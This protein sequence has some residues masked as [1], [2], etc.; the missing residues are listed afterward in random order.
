MWALNILFGLAIMGNFFLIINR[1]PWFF[2]MV[3]SLISAAGVNAFYT[4]Y[5]LYPFYLENALQNQSIR[6][7][8]ILI[9][10]GFFLSFLLEAY[11]F[12]INVHLPKKKTA[13]ISPAADITSTT[14]AD[15]SLTGDSNSSDPTESV[16]SSELTPPPPSD[17][18]ETQKPA[19]TETAIQP[20]TQSG[21]V[22]Q[23]EP[24]AVNPENK[25]V[26]PPD[27]TADSQNN[28]L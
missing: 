12:G 15:S 14:P 9:L 20:P 26:L 24:V 1:P 21:L 27:Q 17:S 6:V 4:I 5:R 8:L 23:S 2:F 3:Q 19:S 28:V 25:P 7:L 22:A 10:I 11:H 16:V 18:S 13:A